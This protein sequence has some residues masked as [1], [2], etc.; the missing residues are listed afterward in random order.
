LRTLP[1][2]ADREYQRH[3]ERG[4]RGPSPRACACDVVAVAFVPLA[5]S[6]EIGGF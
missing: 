6:R 3:G 4:E 1:D 5:T 2:H